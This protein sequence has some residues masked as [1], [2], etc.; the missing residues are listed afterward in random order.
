MHKGCFCHVSFKVAEV[1]YVME[2]DVAKDA[3]ME[4]FILSETL[5]I[6]KSELDDRG[7]AVPL[8]LICEVL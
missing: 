5:S 3:S 6:L 2:A 4:A 7:V 8:H 1:F